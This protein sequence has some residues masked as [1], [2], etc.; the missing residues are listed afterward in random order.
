MS[1]Y[2][3]NFG[4]F[5]GPSDTDKLYNML[6]IVGEG[7]EL[8]ITI[9]AADATQTDTI[10]RVLKENGFDVAT[11]GGH[12]GTHFNITAKRRSQMFSWKTPEKQKKRTEEMENMI[13]DNEM[14]DGKA[15]DVDVGLNNMG[16][17]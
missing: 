13:K 17:R 2:R 16:L 11:K 8:H 14:H 1:D 5:I 15:R 9:E 10:M 3:I 4:N 7:D 6:G 12:D